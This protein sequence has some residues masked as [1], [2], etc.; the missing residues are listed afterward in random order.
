MEVFPMSDPTAPAQPSDPQPSTIEVVPHPDTTTVMHLSG[1]LNRESAPHARAEIVA[2]IAEGHSNLILDVR[3]VPTI[4]GAGANS[5][6]FGMHRAQDAGGELRLVAPTDEVRQR[7]AL[8]DLDDVLP[9]HDTV[10]EALEAD[11][12]VADARSVTEP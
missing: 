11:E 9:I 5:L 2:A 12:A 10:V 4:D 8:G 1:P 3:D 6:L 7:L